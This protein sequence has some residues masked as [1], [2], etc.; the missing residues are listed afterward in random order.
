MSKSVYV[1]VCHIEDSVE[2]ERVFVS[3]LMAEK[4]IAD[5]NLERGCTPEELYYVEVE[6]DE[7]LAPIEEN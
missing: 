1:V 5:Q 3:R 7:T 2:I 4:Y 6:L